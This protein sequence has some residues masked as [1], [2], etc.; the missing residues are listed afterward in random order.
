VYCGQVGGEMRKEYAMVGDT[1][2]TAARLMASKASP[3]LVDYHVKTSTSSSFNYDQLEPIQFKGK[4]APMPVF[5]PH[6]KEFK[7][8]QSQEDIGF[9][10]QNH[11]RDTL[12]NSISNINKLEAG[13]FHLITGSSGMGKSMVMKYVQNKCA[14]QEA[15]VANFC[16]RQI[17]EDTSFFLLA[18][19]FHHFA[20]QTHEE[21]KTLVHTLLDE[22]SPDKEHQKKLLFPAMAYLLRLQWAFDPESDSPATVFHSSTTIPMLE[23]SSAIKQVERQMTKYIIDTILPNI[24]VMIIDDC[25]FFDPNSFDVLHNIT[26]EM[27]KGKKVVV[28]FTRPTSSNDTERAEIVKLKSLTTTSDELLPFEQEVVSE[29]LDKK[30]AEHLAAEDNAEISF[31]PGADDF[32]EVLALIMRE[33]KGN[34]FW[35]MN[36]VNIFKVVVAKGEHKKLFDTSFNDAKSQAFGVLNRVILIEFDGYSSAQQELLKTASTIGTVFEIR[37]LKKVLPVTFRRKHNFETQMKLLIDIGV[38]QNYD[39]EK[40]DWFCEFVHDLTRRA[41]ESLIPPSKLSMIHKQVAET[42]EYFYQDDLRPLF[43]RLA[44]HYDKSG[45]ANE[46]FVYLR[47]A[48][49]TELQLDSVQQGMEMLERAIAVIN[50]NNEN[51]ESK[52]QKVEQLV[53]LLRSC[54]KDAGFSEE[55][56][57]SERETRDSSMAKQSLS[58]FIHHKY[59]KLLVVLRALQKFQQQGGG[60]TSGGGSSDVVI[61][62]RVSSWK[63]MPALQDGDMDSQRVSRRENEGG[64]G[65]AGDKPAED[66]PPAEDSARTER[67]K[68]TIFCTIL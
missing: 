35:V 11:I 12:N 36:F 34:P 4:N 16:G 18:E 47:L 8:G 1:V 54:L 19:M 65:E 45:M 58:N 67:P 32:E 25:Q 46:S 48:A 5:V 29:I 2:N 57:I 64:D 66:N 23:R 49:T 20:P 63:I 39:H 37:I 44:Y 28:M 31:R 15:T 40:K 50:N 52:M 51:L 7:K 38:I 55:F 59:H 9:Y 6:K 17:E 53:M 30:V 27:V 41:I 22:I 68:D 42:Y 21:Q 62:R 13:A 26:T 60:D 61:K 56:L 33:S 10:G 43:P 14:Q 3:M 24:D